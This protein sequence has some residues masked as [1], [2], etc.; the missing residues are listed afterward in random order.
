MKSSSKDQIAGKI[1]QVKGEIKQKAGRLTNN[2]RLESEGVGEK[3]IG[4]VQKK[5]GQ[6]ERVVEK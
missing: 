6:V 4:S 3:V 5:I 2:P 1:H